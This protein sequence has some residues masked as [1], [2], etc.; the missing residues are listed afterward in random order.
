MN[1]T[2]GSSRLDLSGYS[3]PTNYDSNLTQ[4]PFPAGSSIDPGE[5]N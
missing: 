1:S 3:W 5:F 2:S 4:W